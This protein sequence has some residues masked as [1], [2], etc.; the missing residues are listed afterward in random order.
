MFI[1]L[2]SIDN[3]TRGFE[4]GNMG[5]RHIVILIKL[6]HVLTLY[7]IYHMTPR[8]CILIIITFTFLVSSRSVVVI[9]SYHVELAI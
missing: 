8:T 3:Q 6:I 7:L 1:C 2:G 5:P 4:A 9:S